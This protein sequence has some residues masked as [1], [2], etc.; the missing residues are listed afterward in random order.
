MQN[1]LQK[2]IRYKN[3]EPNMNK[4]MQMQVNEI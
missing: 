3:K 4:Q 1:A 2:H